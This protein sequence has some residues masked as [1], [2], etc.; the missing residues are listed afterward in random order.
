MKAD[1][2]V[3]GTTVKAVE[4]PKVQVTAVKTTTASVAPLDLADPIPETNTITETT[5]TDSVI[6]EDGK[7]RKRTTRSVKD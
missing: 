5:V 7:V 2:E 3:K 4:K 1:L 6:T